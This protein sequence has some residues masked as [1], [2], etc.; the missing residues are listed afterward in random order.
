MPNSPSGLKAFLI[1]IGILL[2]L[3]VCLIAIAMIL[4]AIGWGLGAAPVLG[5]YSDQPQ[6]N[7][8]RIDDTTLILTNTGEGRRNVTSLLVSIDSR[9]AGPI[10]LSNGSVLRLYAP[11]CPAIV[12]IRTGFED[13]THSE[14]VITEDTCT[15]DIAT[16]SI[17]R[18]NDT[19]IIRNAG[20]PGLERAEELRVLS[21]SLGN[22]SLELSP[23]SSVTLV[24]D[25][26]WNAKISVAALLGNGVSKTLG[27]VTIDHDGSAEI[28]LS[29]S[30]G[31]CAGSGDTIGAAGMPERCCDGLTAVGGW[32]GGYA[33]DC[34]FPPPPTGLVTCS[35]CGDGACSPGTGENHCNC[36]GDCSP[37]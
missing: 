13:G 4:L 34:S 26:R 20:G 11:V 9:D 7:V 29:S 21:S 36:P 33:G 30:L 27:T 6:F 17:S 1:A 37:P 14:K 31:W 10:G 28:P 5:R 23:G 25:P 16:I 32:P 24:I 22:R 8:T 3:L 2:V 18:H 35:A 12:E 19:I 15:N